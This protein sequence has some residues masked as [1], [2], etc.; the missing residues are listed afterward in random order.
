MNLYLKQIWFPDDRWEKD[1]DIVTITPAMIS[2]SKL[3]KIFK[4]FPE[5]SIDTGITE[6]FAT[7]LACAISLNNKKV[8]LPIYSSFLQRA[9]DNINHDICRM[10]AHVVIGID[11]A[12]LVG[13]DGDTHHGVFD[14]SFLNSIPNMVICMGK[15][16]EEIRNLLYTGFY[17]QKN[18]S[19]I[20]YERA[21]LEYQK[22]T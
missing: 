12:G 18:P 7:T 19:C 10:N 6:S 13:E 20:R 16:N 2:G 8:F 22:Q 9:Y 3:E 11:R 14:I 5:R 1:K 17:K 21:N 4:D 15:D